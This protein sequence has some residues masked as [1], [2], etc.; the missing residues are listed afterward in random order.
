MKNKF[1]ILTN[2]LLILCLLLTAVACGGASTTA[3]EDTTNAPS[4]TSAKDT[5]ASVPSDEASTSNENNSLPDIEVGTLP[6]YPGDIELDLPTLQESSKII[7]S[8]KNGNVIGAASSYA[9]T[10][11]Q[12]ITSYKDFQSMYGTV[13]GMTEAF[14]EDHALVLVHTAES[15]GSTRYAVDS[16]TMVDGTIHVE[17][18]EQHAAMSTRDLRVWYVFAAV[19]K[20][21]A[22]LPVEV[23]VTGV[24]LAA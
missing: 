12:N 9:P 10:G 22:Q 8:V 7:L 14:F 3:P 13:E 1:L 6:L 24:Q 21:H 11:N 5:E 18:I 17:I 15:S 4:D 20:G 23:N 2:V 19:K 16:V